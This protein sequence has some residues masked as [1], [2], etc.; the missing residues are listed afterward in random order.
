VAREPNNIVWLEGR[1][2]ALVDGKQFARALSDY[3]KCAP[4]CPSASSHPLVDATP[5]LTQRT[6]CALARY[7]EAW[8]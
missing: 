6:T 4:P 1:A 8:V 7:R 3:N 5:L 2:Q